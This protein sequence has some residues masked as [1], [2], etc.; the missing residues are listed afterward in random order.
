MTG[1]WIV[2]WNTRT[3]SGSPMTRFC[4]V[5][6]DDPSHAV[7]VARE[8]IGGEPSLEIGGPLTADQLRRRKLQR[9]AVLVLGRRD[10]RR[11]AKQHQD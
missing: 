7:V 11:M 10:Q 3:A 5:A 6:I 1:G 2:R 4:L 9:G 8:S